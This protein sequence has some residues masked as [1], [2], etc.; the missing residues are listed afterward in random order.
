MPLRLGPPADR[1]GSPPLIPG[2]GPVTPVLPQSVAGEVARCRVWPSPCRP[3]A[4]FVTRVSLWPRLS[5]LP[6]RPLMLFAIFIESFDFSMLKLESSSSTPDRSPLSY[7]RFANVFCRPAA[8]RFTFLNISFFGS[9]FK[10]SLRAV[11][12]V[13]RVVLFMPV[14]EVFAS[15]QVMNA[16]SYFF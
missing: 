15:P 9:C 1:P 14:S 7:R 3:A 8:R 6:K 2:N 13:R 12:C 11:C 16:F 5:C 10:F 4:G